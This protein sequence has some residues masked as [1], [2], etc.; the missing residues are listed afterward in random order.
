MPGLFHRVRLKL[1]R[2]IGK[3][4]IQPS[5]S[6]YP[7]NIIPLHERGKLTRHASRI[8][9]AR[10]NMVARETQRL[11]NREIS[12]GDYAK[13]VEKINEKTKKMINPRKAKMDELLKRDPKFPALMNDS[14]FGEIAGRKLKQRLQMPNKGEKIAI[15]I[16]DLDFFHNFNENHGHPGGDVAL[17]IYSEVL[18]DLTEAKGIGIAGRHGGEEMAIML[19]GEHNPEQFVSQIKAEVNRRFE[20]GKDIYNSTLDRDKKITSMPTFTAG[21]AQAPIGQIRVYKEMMQEADSCLTG[22]KK[23]NQRGSVASKEVQKLIE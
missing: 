10:E 11:M 9:K 22:L 13:R 18:H 19:V 20:T 8:E 12:R 15:F 17:K 16:I 23:T 1:E 21:Y 3:K 6:K 7:V 5:I 14:Y 4:K 2:M